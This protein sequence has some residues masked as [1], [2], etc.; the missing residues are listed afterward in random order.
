MQLK[1]LELINYMLDNKVKVL[2]SQQLADALEISIRSVKT[3]ISQINEMSKGKTIISNKNGYTLNVVNA[4]ILIAEEKKVIPQ[5]YEERSN[6]LIKTFFLNHTNCLN[7]F[8]MADELFVSDST[9]KM[10][11]RKMN[12]RFKSFHIEFNIEKD[13][14][15]L[16]GPEKQIRKLFSHI[17]YEEVDNHYVDLQILNNN[18]KNI[19]IESMLLII[20]QTF[21]KNDFFIND[22]ALR[23]MLLHL[24]IIIER[25]LEGRTISKEELP[26]SLDKEEDNTC[27]SELCRRLEQLFGITISEFERREIY[28]LFKSNTN[29]MISHNMQE[30]ELLVGD[31]IVEET[32]DLVY[33]IQQ[34]YCVNLNTENFIVPFALHL[35]NLM[36]RAKNN[37][38]MKNPMLETIKSQH[39]ILFDI[40]LYVALQLEKKHQISIS[41]DEVAFIALHIGG[42]IERQKSNNAKVRVVLLCPSYMNIESRLFNE[43]L[44]NFSNDINIITSVRDL[45]QLEGLNYEMLISTVR[46]K[47]RG[48]CEV[49]VISPFMTQ[50][51]KY[52]IQEK[53]ENSQ[54]NKKKKMLKR[55]F[56]NYFEKN[57]FFVSQAAC[58]KMQTI[59]ILTDRLYEMEYVRKDYKENLLMREVAA[60][61]AF[62]KMAIPHSV[63]MNAYKTC[64]SVMISSKGIRWDNQLVNVVL[65]IAINKLDNNIFKELYESLVI[66]FSEE[67]NIELF[68]ECKSFAEFEDT[69][70][71]IIS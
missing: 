1:Q 33:L 70:N 43:I 71:S 25:I 18:F 29:L 9:L 4:R 45:Q 13:N 58:D 31:V 54:N 61:T 26:F 3:Y 63:E 20:R 67:S 2:T 64:A 30:L 36:L 40:A 48:Q 57:L 15:N 11:I 66:I 27:V 60:S 49:A 7:L 34:E 47:P 55:D 22:L 53:I 19:D 16:F 51:D 56:N 44:I 42:E 37:S 10:D 5:T 62:G 32:K 38:Y 41:Q 24:V 8:E 12:M 50:G 46:I 68:K 14:I 23:N 28:I 52:E 69:L 65:M 21:S 59:D 6:Y 35:K 17:L 39:L